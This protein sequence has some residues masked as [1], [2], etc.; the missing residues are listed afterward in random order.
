MDSKKVISEEISRM[1]S[2]FGYQRGKVI[3][4]QEFNE[5]VIG[6]YE[7]A[8]LNKVDP[9]TEHRT[10]DDIAAEKA[11]TPAKKDNWY[12]KHPDLMKFFKDINQFALDYFPKAGMEQTGEILGKRKDGKTFFGFFPDNRFYIYDNEQNGLNGVKW[13]NSGTWKEEG[14]NVIL[15]T[16]DGNSYTTATHKWKSEGKGGGGST[17]TQTPTELKDVNG[18]KAFQDWLDVNKAG[19]ATGYANNIL[20]KTGSGYGRMGP[21]TTKAWASYKDEYL[22]GGQTQNNNPYSDYT[23]V[24][25]SGNTTKQGV[26]GDNDTTQPAPQQAQQSAQQAPA[27]PTQKSPQPPS[28]PGEPG[29]ERD[30]WTFDEKRQTWY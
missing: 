24:E 30:G 7:R 19:W 11:K 23:A 13:T 17:V 18:V 3:S 22:K 16:K 29:E 6:S 9:G 20:N 5:D 14:G 27:Q 15:T 12:D 10:A 28:E 8:E 1:K 2:L 21:R 4:E 26:E 25:D